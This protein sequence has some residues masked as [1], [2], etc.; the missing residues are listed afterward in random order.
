MCT[1]SAGN[2]VAKRERERME[3]PGGNVSSRLGEWVEDA[4]QGFRNL[5]DAKR[6][7]D[8]VY[9][10]SDQKLIFKEGMYAGL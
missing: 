9:R 2:G 6:H 8:F 10:S 7:T 1:L 3:C 5:A 4:L